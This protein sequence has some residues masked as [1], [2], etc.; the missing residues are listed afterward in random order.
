MNL[1]EAK[2]LLLAQIRSKDGVQHPTNSIM[3][4]HVQTDCEKGVW[5]RVWGLRRGEE[6][7]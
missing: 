1:E 4:A 6:E 2:I 7:C 3:K 5:E